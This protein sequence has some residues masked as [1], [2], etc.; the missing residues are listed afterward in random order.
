MAPIFT[1]E[2]DVNGQPATYH[3]I[4]N[5]GKYIF[6]PEGSNSN[7]GAFS[8]IRTHDEW[9]VEGTVA[10]DLKKQGLAKLED[11]LLAQL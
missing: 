7:E 5:E 11:Y 3:V 1:T 10:E 4:F 6:Q 9:Q 8:A 2:L